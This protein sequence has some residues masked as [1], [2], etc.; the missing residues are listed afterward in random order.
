MILRACLILSFA[1][2]SFDVQAQGVALCE[3]FKE[4]STK[5]DVVLNDKDLWEV[6][7][8]SLEELQELRQM[9]FGRWKDPEENGFWISDADETIGGF[10]RAGFGVDISYAFTVIPYKDR[11]RLSCVF[12]DDI[13]VKIHYTGVTFIDP[14]YDDVECRDGKAR[15]EEHLR[16]RYGIG[17]GAAINTHIKIQK[18]LPKIIPK[19]EYA[20]VKKDDALDKVEKIKKSLRGGI[21]NY[22]RAMRDEIIDL[23]IS[24]EVPEDMINEYNQ[25]TKA[26]PVRYKD[27]SQ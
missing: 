27:K 13:K 21:D 6:T 20:A 12:V 14:L 8:Y 4:V 16:K 5:I 11:D 17:V 25:C 10:F 9:R 1:L 19:M 26:I 24:M 15:M 23:N 18:E 22:A 2:L 7:G 3:P